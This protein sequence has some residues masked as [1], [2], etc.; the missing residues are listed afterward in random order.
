MSF[1]CFCV[2]VYVCVSVYCCTRFPEKFL[3]S[4]W[5]KIVTNVSDDSDS[6]VSDKIMSNG[7]SDDDNNNSSSSNCYCSDSNNSSIDGK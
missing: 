4:S 5:L 7:C 3:F 1:I 6:G 2:Y